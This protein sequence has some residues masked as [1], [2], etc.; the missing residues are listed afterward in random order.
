MRRVWLWALALASL[1][2]ALAA[3]PL[4]PLL[5]KRT[6]ARIAESYATA[7]TEQQQVI[8]QVVGPSDTSHSKDVTQASLTMPLLRLDRAG[9]LLTA[10]TQ[11]YAFFASVSSAYQRWPQPNCL[12]IRQNNQ[13]LINI[14]GDELLIPASG[15][16]LLTAIGVIEHFDLDERLI[17]RVLSDSMPVDGVLEGDIW[18]QGGADPLVATATYAAALSRQPQLFTDIGDLVNELLELPITAIN[19][20]ILG[21]ESRHDTI[22]YVE[23]W[24]ARYR[25]EFNTGPL[26]ALTV[27]DGLTAIG[28]Q[29]LITTDPALAFVELLSD[30]M[31][32]RGVEMDV[33]FG[34]GKTPPDAIELASI[35]SPTIREMVQQM[36]RESDNNTAEILLRE[37]GL[38]VNGVGSTAAGAAVVEQTVSEL[39]KKLMGEK[40][41]SS[42]LLVAVDGS[43]L[44]R[45]NLVTCAQLTELLDLYGQESVIG[46]GLPVAAQSGTLSH[47]FRNHPA[48]G[49][50]AAKTGL[51]TGV[52]ALA[53]FL[54]TPTGIFTFA[55]IING[56]PRGTRDGL[57]SQEQLVRVLLEH[58]VDC[59]AAATAL[60]APWN[61]TETTVDSSDTANAN[62]S[63]TCGWFLPEGADPAPVSTGSD[64][65]EGSFSYPLAFGVQY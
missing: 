37:L 9:Q 15:Q 36:L 53:G 52:N 8:R 14:N 46:D 29:P 28:F 64:S 7:L 49:A 45:G 6:D 12:S 16:K 42:Q 47:R 60:A 62:T 13:T 5:Q 35:Q 24:P 2:V 63:P 38:R 56:V 10:A 25:R 50:L 65:S 11:Q 3:L 4:V 32:V 43:G 54:E 55:Q 58:P 44:D 41:G 22:R 19:G 27:N 40:N 61:G 21:D 1:T 31:L 30:L 26:S 23:S 33:T 48:A 59:A 57:D 17:T 18:V 20:S 34:I 39:L 51:L